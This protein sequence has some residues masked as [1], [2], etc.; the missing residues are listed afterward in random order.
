MIQSCKNES[1]QCE[2]FIEI[3]VDDDSNTKACFGSDDQ[4]EKVF[5]LCWHLET[6]TIVFDF[7]NFVE[8]ALKLEPTKHNILKVVST[9]FDILG[10]LGSIIIQTKRI[11]KRGTLMHE[12]RMI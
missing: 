11:F 9:L 10:L 7:C 3:N 8:G 2:P 4:F 6:D 1:S 12:T 5:G